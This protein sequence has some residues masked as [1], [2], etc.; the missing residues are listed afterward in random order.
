MSSKNPKRHFHQTTTPTDKTN[1]DR[2]DVVTPYGEI[3]FPRP[4][5]DTYNNI[6]LVGVGGFIAI[7]ATATALCLSRK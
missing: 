3:H 6:L 4:D 1:G 2:I 5:N 7:A